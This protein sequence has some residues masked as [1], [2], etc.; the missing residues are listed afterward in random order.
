MYTARLVVEAEGIDEVYEF[1]YEVDMMDFAIS[2]WADYWDGEDE[3]HIY[4]TERGDG[5]PRE[6]WEDPEES[7]E[8]VEYLGGEE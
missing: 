8:L 5:G 6:D 2:T 3:F 4:I 1:E 7:T